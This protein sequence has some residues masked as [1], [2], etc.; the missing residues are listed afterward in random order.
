MSDPVSDVL[1]SQHVLEMSLQHSRGMAWDGRL[2][3]GEEVGRL[4]SHAGLDWSGV[5]VKKIV[6]LLDLQTWISLSGR[7]GLES[8]SQGVKLWPSMSYV[9]TKQ[10]T[11]VPNPLYSGSTMGAYASSCTLCVTISPSALI[12]KKSISIHA[13]NGVNGGGRKR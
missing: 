6:F 11:E 5:L 3:D 12:Q 7:E 2:K 8:E 1:S 9:C 4:G 10:D 13:V